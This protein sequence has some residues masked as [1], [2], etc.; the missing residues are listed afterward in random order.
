MSEFINFLQTNFPTLT[1]LFAGTG[2][3][4]SAYLYN[5]RHHRYGYRTGKKVVI[6]F[7]SEINKRL[8]SPHSQ[9]SMQE[10]VEQI[11]DMVFHLGLSEYIKDYNQRVSRL[12]QQINSLR[13]EAKL[14]KEM[15]TKLYEDKDNKL[16]GEIQELEHS[17]N[18][19]EEELSQ[20]KK[21]EDERNE[22]LD[23]DNKARGQHTYFFSTLIQRT[24]ESLDKATQKLEADLLRYA[25]IGIIAI[26]LYGDY[27]ISYT[28]VNDLFK[29]EYRNK[30]QIVIFSI[31]FMVVFLVFAGLALEALDRYSTK[32]KI[33]VNR[34]RAVSVLALALILT[35]VY[36]FMIILSALEAKVELLDSI[37]R[38]MFVPMVIAVALVIR[39]V[40]KEYGF[41]FLFT[42][43]KA[44]LHL[45][46]ILL[47]SVLLLFEVVLNYIRK[48]IQKERFE[49]RTKLTLAEEVDNIRS[50]ITTKSVLRSGLKQQ[51]EAE[52]NK[53]TEYY[54]AL[55]TK[56]EEKLGSLNT[57]M[58]RVRKGC[59]SGVVAALKLPD[60]VIKL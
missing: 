37:L 27:S 32:Y 38:I 36:I 43:I 18:T 29:I 44:I 12:E 60:Q 47:F 31:I 17:L 28:I 10:R 11:K 56:L 26:L 39:K 54:Q 24:R 52:I 35:V 34:I 5:T 3:V 48:Y 21:L 53:I 23:Q 30:F 19:K 42:P 6:S 50:E 15:A 16:E 40:Q 49:S 46:L 59:E 33:L 20:L 41:S 55:F 4:V 22:A 2:A 13:E 45:I 58:A 7:R 8:T 1:T 25:Y 57:E 14:K 51:L 9:K